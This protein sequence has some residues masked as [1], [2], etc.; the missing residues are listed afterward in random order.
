MTENS[1][2]IRTLTLDG[3]RVSYLHGG[4]GSLVLLLHGTFW[5]HVWLPILPKLAERHAVFAPGY[6]GF[7]CSKG[8]LEPE[9]ATAPALADLVL[10]AE[11]VAL[12]RADACLRAGIRLSP[13]RPLELSTGTPE[14]EDGARDWRV[15]LRTVSRWT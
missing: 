13:G 5:S 3:R 8:R 7:G 4:E 15:E 2:Q 14:Y 6:P 12:S 9:E 10:R 1:I 11:D